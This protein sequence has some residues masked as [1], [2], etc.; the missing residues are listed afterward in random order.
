[1]VKGF[2]VTS[3]DLV[4]IIQI[5]LALA[6]L[7]KDMA[8]KMININPLE[9]K[10]TPSTDKVKL[11]MYKDKL[12]GLKGKAVQKQYL[13]IIIPFFRKFVRDIKKMEIM[14]YD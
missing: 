12:T 6:E 8:Y 1:M 9:A 5:R 4:T 3:N 11:M 14:V 7:P 13:N 2:K 10:I